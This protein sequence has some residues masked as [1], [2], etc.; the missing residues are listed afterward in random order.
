M[1]YRIATILLL[2]GT[3][4][5]QIETE[6]PKPPEVSEPAHWAVRAFVST[7]DLRMP[8]NAAKE[9]EKA[10]RLIASRNWRKATERLR[11]GLAIYPQYAAGYNNLG[12]IYSQLG[13]N[14]P[15]R[16]ALSR[17]IALDDRL[18]PAYV[19]LGRLSFLENDFP[20]AESLLSRA[21]SLAPALNADELYLLAYAEL[22]NRHL[23]QA[24]ETSRSAHRGQMDRH[25]RLHLIAANAFERQ[26]K[27]PDSIAELQT[28][29]SEEA[30]GPRSDKVREVLAK[31]QAQAGLVH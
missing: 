29:L 15:A 14:V 4:S 23:N 17:A 5:A 6:V 11:R 26:G 16:E 30:S 10:N 18:A 20:A 2:L 27:I 21:I 25:A 28:Y 12:A 13:N 9:F 7:T 31:L 19:N 3:A 24:I 22:S 8:S 1:V